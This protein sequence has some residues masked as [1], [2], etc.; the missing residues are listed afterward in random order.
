MWVILLAAVIRLVGSSALPPGLNAAEVQDVQLIERVHG[1]QVEVLYDTGTEG[2]EGLY[3]ILVAIV[4]AFIG[5][6]PFGYRM[7]SVWAGLLALALVYTFARRLYGRVAGIVA[8]AV[9]V[10]PFWSLMLSRTITRETLLPLIVTLTLTAL[11]RALPVYRRPT[12]NPGTLPFG[13]LG[14]VLG[15]GFYVHPAHYLIVLLCMVFIAYM[16]L[17]RQPMSRRTLSYLSFSIVILVIVAT[18]YLISSLR[19]P[20]LSGATRLTDEYNV[21]AEAG[22]GQ[23]LLNSLSGLFWRGDTNLLHNVPARP[24]IDG[25]SVIVMLVGLVFAARHMM[26][27]RYALVVLAAVT[28]LPAALFAPNSPN[29]M[30]YSLIVPLLAL[31]FSLGVKW[32]HRM[33]RFLPRWNDAL[34]VGVAV[35]LGGNLGW[36]L[37]SYYNG[38]GQDDAVRAAYHHRIHEIAKYLDTTVSGTNTVA[39]VPQLPQSTPI[40]LGDTDNLATL[41]ALMMD[42]PDESR[43]RY[44]DCGSGLVLANGGAHQQLILLQPDM[45]DEL[46]PYVRGWVTQGDIIYDGV[47]PNS[48][49]SLVVDDPLENTIGRFTT[50]A[51]AGYAPESPGG[52]APALLPVNFDAPLTFLGYDPPDVTYASGEVATII[53]YWRVDGELPPDLS[54]FT[55]ILFDAQTI[56]SQTDTISVLPERLH[57]R[58]VFIQVTFVPLPERLPPGIYQTSTGAYE[59]DEDTRLNVLYNGHPRGTRLFI[60]EIRVQ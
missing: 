26:Q 28:L 48:V 4:T 43:I 55:H 11:V 2:R 39:C 52:V 5:N 29:F 40:T 47:P 33:V 54:L 34:A 3:H 25:V 21:I 53:T 31:L 58:D 38:W 9:M 13:I 44:V 59:Q 51:P 7:L 24:Y 1:G 10:V 41:L 36:T 50:T 12:L 22:I 16:I 19:L 35:L 14:L 23:T 60:N 37:A 45:L 56:V 49:V 6:D 18:P 42:N 30:A 8:M 32:L 57:N 46:H 17:T 20:E 15:L 27:P